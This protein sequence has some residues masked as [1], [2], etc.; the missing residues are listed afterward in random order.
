ML[1]DEGEE[2]RIEIGRG[3]TIKG[4]V[5][6][7]GNAVVIGETS[8]ISN[9]DVRIVGN[10]NN[11]IIGKNSAIRDIS[12]MVGSYTQAFHASVHIGDGFSSEENCKLF[13]YNSGNKVEIGEDCMFS[14]S[15]ILRTGEAPHLIF[16]LNSGKY[17]DEG[18]H[19][20]VGAHSW[21]GERSYMTKRAKVAPESIVA[22]C[23]VVTTAFEERNVVL[24][25]NPAKIVKRG[26]QW[27]RNRSSLED[28][29]SFKRSYTESVQ[30]FKS[31][32]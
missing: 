18:G 13:V 15:V 29:S 2:N 28:G 25:G 3:I 5:R 31:R 17:I 23:S 8:G 12:I 16:D 6:G 4:F 32:K 24:G 20:I 21:I 19:I 22:A 26:V 10:N 30:S 7:T 27:I 11:V 9:I 1:L 14:N